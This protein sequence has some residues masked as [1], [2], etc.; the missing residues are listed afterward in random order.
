MSKVNGSQYPVGSG[1]RHVRDT[2]LYWST[3]FFFLEREGGVVRCWAVWARALV[4]RL[5]DVTKGSRSISTRAC[6]AHS[7]PLFSIDRVPSV[8]GIIV[9]W[10]TCCGP[11]ELAR[12]PYH[13]ES[14]VQSTGNNKT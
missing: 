10:H 12:S 7:F 13:R 4:V 11:L 8:D 5:I 9:W 1:S 2:F 6:Q 3:F 14:N